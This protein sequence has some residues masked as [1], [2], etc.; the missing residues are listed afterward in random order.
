MTNNKKY[1]ERGI[2]MTC[3]NDSSC[4]YSRENSEQ[5]SQCEEFNN[6]SHKEPKSTNKCYSQ[7]KSSSNE[8]DSDKYNGLCKNCENR[9]SCTL[10]KPE[11][12]IWHCQEYR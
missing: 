10:N 9:K 4:M 6:G 5:V 7:Q 12:G 1:M 2:C 8:S 11:G 3:D